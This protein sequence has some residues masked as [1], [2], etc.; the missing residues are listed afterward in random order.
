MAIKEVTQHWI[1]TCDCC[2]E[3]TNQ[4]GTHRPSTW[5]SVKIGADAMD[6]VGFPVADASRDLLFCQTCGS[7]VVKAINA[8]AS[9]IRT[10]LSTPTEEPKT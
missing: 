2:A 7:A 8:A 6:Y 4:T 10:A 1:L 5:V 3:K 9:A